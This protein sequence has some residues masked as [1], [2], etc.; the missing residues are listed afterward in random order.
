MTKFLGIALIF[1]AIFFVAD[2]LYTLRLPK[3]AQILRMYVGLPGAGKSTIAAAFARDRIKRGMTVLSN[4]PILGTYA[5]DKA[6]FGK[7]DISNCEVEIDEAGIA[8]NNR[9]LLGPDQVEWFKLHRHHGV[10]I[11]FFSQRSDCEITIRSM[12]YE[13][14]LVKKSLIPYMVTFIRYPCALKPTF[15]RDNFTP[16]FVEPKKVK[17]TFRIWC[18][19]VWKMFDSW[20]A[21]KL[22]HKDFVLWDSVSRYEDLVDSSNFEFHF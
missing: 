3:P 18:P 17:D 11:N 19:S 7:V 22:P 21:P 20:E 15:E 1:G 2:V 8:F 14:Y 10:A 9:V 13:M 6:D 4:V 16:Q 12:V 5:V